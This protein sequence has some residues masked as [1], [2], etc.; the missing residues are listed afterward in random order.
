MTTA[1]RKHLEARLL[2]ERDRVTN[3]LG[4]YAERHE[5]EDEQDEAGDLTFF[6]QKGRIIVGDAGVSHTFMLG[7]AEIADHE[8]ASEISHYFRVSTAK[9]SNGMGK[10]LQKTGRDSDRQ[11]AE[12]RFATDL[13]G[14]KV[15]NGKQEKIGE[16]LDLL[17][18]FGEPHP[19]FVVLSTG[20]LFHREHQYA[21]PLSAF[22]HSDGKLVLD[23]DAATLQQALPF[24]QAAWKSGGTNSLHPFYQYSTP[25][26]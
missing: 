12:L 8:H 13:M 4:R 25:G 2:Q 1:Q 11:P 6:D 24:D 9:P 18:S 10:T 22:K 3:L 7:L 16:V 20:R 15:V 26:E 17:V 19:A 23:A 14:R 21:V 5:G